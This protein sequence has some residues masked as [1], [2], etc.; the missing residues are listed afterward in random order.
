MLKKSDYYLNKAKYFY[1]IAKINNEDGESDEE[2]DN[3]NELSQY[4]YIK[5]EPCKIIETNTP[6]EKSDNNNLKIKRDCQ[7]Y[8]DPVTKH[9][10][11]TNDIVEQIDCPNDD[12]EQD[13]W[14]PKTQ[15]DQK[16]FYDPK[17]KKNYKINKIYDKCCNYH[18][19]YDILN[20]KPK[21]IIGTNYYRP[22][23]QISKI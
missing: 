4:E 15:P 10:Y 6:N 9:Y 8:Y 17:T 2:D 13:I 7:R 5:L 1:D 22:Y 20:Y 12:Y 18:Y 11:K 14:F 16:Y 3:D 21:K 23:Y 19:E